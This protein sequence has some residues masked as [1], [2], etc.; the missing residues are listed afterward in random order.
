MRMPGLHVCLKGADGGQAADTCATLQ[1]WT[2]VFGKIRS[3]LCAMQIVQAFAAPCTI[4]AD[5][6]RSGRRQGDSAVV[7][8][9]PARG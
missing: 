2:Q 3:A 7:A 1:L 4:V 5:E 9:S 6:W 8:G